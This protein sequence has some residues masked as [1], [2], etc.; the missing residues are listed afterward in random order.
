L[1]LDKYQYLEP[2][3]AQEKTQYLI[4]YMDYLKNHPTRPNIGKCMTA[5][6]D[7]LR[8][9]IMDSTIIDNWSVRG[10]K[11]SIL[12]TP[13][14]DL[15]I[16]KEKTKRW[17]TPYPF[18]KHIQ[19]TYMLKPLT[20]DNCDNFMIGLGNLLSYQFGLR[21][22]ELCYHKASDRNHA[23]MA[24]DVTFYQDSQVGIGN[25]LYPWELQPKNQI[26][27]CPKRSKGITPD[28][29]FV[30]LT[31]DQSGVHLN[32]LVGGIP[33]IQVSSR[34][35]GIQMVLTHPFRK[36]QERSSN[37][38]KRIQI[39]LRSQKNHQIGITRTLDLVRSATST[40]QADMLMDDLI[41]FSK[42]SRTIASDPF[43]CRWK[44]DRKLLQ[45]KMVSNMLK[46]V[47]AILG[48]QKD[49]FSSHSN[50]SGCASKLH[51]AGLPVQDISSYIG[52]TSDAV[53]G[54]LHDAPPS[55]LDLGEFLE[56]GNQ[57]IKRN[58]MRG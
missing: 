7:Y 52:W 45:P 42:F 44:E 55:T 18:I 54:Y 41:L 36:Q 1:A 14:R 56:S 38:I 16:E 30:V 10:A 11:V 19:S 34:I 21:V 12:R 9:G 13:G 57:T 27:V 3:G 26:Y 49:H 4:L 6:S 39:Q 46:T 8:S 37:S 2:W 15:S 50:R 51:E 22:S 58:L 47:A 5:L 33:T 32:N 53:F 48:Y 29:Y 17:P 20:W 35:E 25:P 43:F 31:G 40:T 28:K 24:S 23:I